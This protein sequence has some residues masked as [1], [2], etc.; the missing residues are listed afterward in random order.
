[1]YLKKMMIIIVVALVQ[2]SFDSLSTNFIIAPNVFIKFVI[3]AL[4]F[5]YGIF[6]IILGIKAVSYAHYV[7][8]IRE[9]TYVILIFTPIIY[10]VMD[11]GFEIV[12]SMILFFPL[13]YYIIELI[14]YYVPDPETVKEDSNTG[15]NNNNFNNNF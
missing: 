9:V 13:F 12:M 10:G 7:G 6:V 5:A 8:R 2:V 15:N 3:C 11:I 14:D 4:V 1:M